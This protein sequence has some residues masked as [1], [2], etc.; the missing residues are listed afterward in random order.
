MPLSRNAA[1]AV[2]NTT[3]NTFAT[4]IDFGLLED[5]GGGCFCLHQ[6]VA[7]YARLQQIDATAQKRLA[8]Y[9]IPYAQ[10]NAHD[11]SIMN[12]EAS[13]ILAALDSARAHAQ[14]PCS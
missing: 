8:A 4:L 12:G 13:N 10:A 3:D 5:T 7:D 6:T 1:C 2:N 11:A 9:F 14:W